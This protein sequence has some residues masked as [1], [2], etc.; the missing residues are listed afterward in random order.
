VFLFFI[1]TLFHQKVVALK[2]EKTYILSEKTYFQKRT[3]E[4]FSSIYSHLASVWLLWN[5]LLCFECVFK[6]IFLLLR[7]EIILHCFDF[8]LLQNSEQFR[9]L[10]TDG[11]LVGNSTVTPEVRQIPANSN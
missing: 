2:E 8:L 6:A 10:L 11:P 9:I 5:M 3:S 7:V 1:E 4:A